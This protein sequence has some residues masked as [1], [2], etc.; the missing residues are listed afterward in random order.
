MPWLVQYEVSAPNVIKKSAY[1][2]QIE[3]NKIKQVKQLAIISLSNKEYS[4][5]SILPADTKLINLSALGIERQKTTQ[6]WI[7]AVGHQNQL[8]K[9]IE[10]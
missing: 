10:L 1:S 3:I 5:E 7:V 6:Y 2:F 8:S 4:V 9:L